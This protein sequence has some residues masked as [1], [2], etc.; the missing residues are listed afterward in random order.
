[1]GQD[2]SNFRS[3]IAEETFP[4]L[5]ADGPDDIRYLS[6]SKASSKAFSD[7]QILEFENDW[8]KRLRTHLVALTKSSSWEEMN[9]QFTGKFIINIMLVIK[10]RMTKNNDEVL[11]RVRHLSDLETALK[12]KLKDDDNL[13]LPIFEQTS[14]D[15]TFPKDQLSYFAIQSLI[16][17][18]LILIKSAEKNDPTIVDQI[19]S[20]TGQLCQQ[21]P[22]K[23]LS[24]MNQLLFKSFEPLTNYIS[25]LSK[26]S[27][28]SKRTTEILLSLAVA[29]GSLKALLVLFNNLIFNTT[30]TFNVQ[31]LLQQINNYLSKNLT[32]ENFQSISWDYLKSLNIYPNS[33][34]NK[35]NSTIFTGQFISSIILSHIDIENELH[36]EQISSVSS[37][38]HP[39]TFQTL[40][41]LIEQCIPSSSSNPTLLHILTVCL[42]L[43]CSH[44]QL[45]FRSKLTL[46]KENDVQTWF[47][48]LLNL[49]SSNDSEQIVREASKA[50]VNVINI[51]ASSFSEKLLCFYQF[52]QEK[53]YPIFIEQLF[54]ELNKTEFLTDWISNLCDKN[55]RNETIDILYSFLDLSFQGNSTIESFISTFQSLLLYRL[56]DQCETKTFDQQSSS[57]IADYLNYFLQKYL[58]SKSVIN[59]QIQTISISLCITTN[60]DVFLYEAI[61]PI[62]LSVLPLLVDY[63]L[64]D[65]N[66][67]WTGF[68]SCLIGRIFQVLII[69]SPYGSLE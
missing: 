58:Q 32:D 26:N 69:G 35:F 39:N 36:P 31:I 25:Q 16:S 53:K 21:L 9:N 56:I 1:M 51:Q 22:M 54:L 67:E 52:I 64:L 38:F 34:L 37:E 33:T 63:Y 28:F 47:D 62:F 66:P 55:Q 20:L 60:T 18:L 17:M 48:F 11:T 6:P 24:S 57:F 68:L 42:R 29:K 45:L 15:V 19:L 49:I 14:N 46:I 4:D 41:H 65:L 5:E 43:F 12:T 13:L 44:L 27:I 40:F 30:E 8:I 59:E 10:E 61:Q 23:S 7:K 2:F 3:E 50:L